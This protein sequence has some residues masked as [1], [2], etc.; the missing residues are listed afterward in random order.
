MGGMRVPTRIVTA[1]AAGGILGILFGWLFNK[2][3]DQDRGLGGHRKLTDREVR[4]LEQQL[5]RDGV[6][7]GVHELK[8]GLNQP[9]GDL[10][11]DDDGTIVLKPRGGRGPGEETGYTRRDLFGR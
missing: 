3:D 10:Y 2:P 5:G 4:R 6:E 7:G 9:N 1:A 11:F 8:R